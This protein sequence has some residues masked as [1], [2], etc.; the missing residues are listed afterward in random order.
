M[1]VDV[2]NTRTSGARP[3]PICRRRNGSRPSD[4]AVFC[5][6]K[7]PRVQKNKTFFLSPASAYVRKPVIGQ[8]VALRLRATEYVLSLRPPNLPFPLC[9]LVKPGWSCSRHCYIFVVHRTQPIRQKAPSLPARWRCQ[10]ARRPRSRR[11]APLARRST[12]PCGGRAFCSG[13]TR[14]PAQVG[15]R[16]EVSKSLA[17]T[18][19][20]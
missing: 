9:S 10:T 15:W 8:S 18:R 2:A 3:T 11:M 13:F 20:R 17:Y 7:I 12:Y 4:T 5:L 16:V 6:V 19:I 14:P 1:F